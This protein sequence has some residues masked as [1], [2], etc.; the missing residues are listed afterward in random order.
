ML[1]SDI[2]HR[3]VVAVVV[4]Q[5]CADPAKLL[6]GRQI[7]SPIFSGV[8]NCVYGQSAIIAER[9]HV[10]AVADGVDP[11]S[12]GP[13]QPKEGRRDLLHRLAPL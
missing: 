12:Y 11:A 5:T 13:K 8:F 10:G 3:D 7:S 4:G 2:V 9:Q 6:R 1:V